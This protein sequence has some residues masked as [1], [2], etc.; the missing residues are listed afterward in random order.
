VRRRL[1]AGIPA[2][3]RSDWHADCGTGRGAAAPGRR[4]TN[5]TNDREGGLHPTTE[6]ERALLVGLDLPGAP[7]DLATSLDELEA[8][9][10]SAGLRPIGRVTQR[11]DSP[12]PRYYVGK[13]KLAE[14]EEYT[15]ADLCDVVVFDDEL[16]PRV[17]QALEDA[18]AV[19][20]IDR[21]LLILDIF[22]RR[23]RTHE[24]RAQVEL[25][26]YQYLLPRL[27]GKGTA[28][29]RLGG[30]IGT[31]GPGE[32]KLEFDRR[33]IRARVAH[34][35]RTID[36]IRRDRE[37][38]RQLRRRR[39][40]LLV[41]LVG[42]TNVGKST[43]LNSLTRAEAYAANLLFATLDP[44]TRRLRLPSGHEVLL[45]D[46]VGLIAKLPTTV[47]A[48]FRATLE[49]LQDA[50]LLLHVVDL[51]HP[52][53]AEQNDI[54]HELLGELGLGE[55]RVLTVINKVDALVPAS[56][57]GPPDPQELG[58]PPS[59]DLVLVSALRGW[60][61]DALL[62][63]IEAT[64]VGEVPTV[65]VMIPYA[66][67]RLVDLFRRRGRVV[68]EQHTAEGTV[69]RGELPRPVARAFTPY[70]RPGGKTRGDGQ[71]TRR[72][73]APARKPNSGRKC[74]P[75]NSVPPP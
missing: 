7:W 26:Q 1:T 25:A 48:A 10:E 50:D 41:A 30:G 31:R 57:D 29:S 44:L 3:S 39:A 5:R 17:Q 15:R 53:A 42:Y 24:G 73:R 40:L 68:S 60:G 72:P 64:L 54:V 62:E 38:H 52:H 65:E 46:T 58:L 59:P 43:L 13:G 32:T 36:E 61:I 74:D 8:L 19:K 67:G 2:Q 70:L 69:L 4:R 18:L 33:R 37:G 20:V 22:A 9:A 75:N 63:R 34:L 27:V 51:T 23:A 66:E 49:E 35:R 21:T 71:A 28:L 45:S 56:S 14:I 6:Q 55:K 11:A 16:P 12:N 47:V